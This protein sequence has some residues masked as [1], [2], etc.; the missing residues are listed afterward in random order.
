MKTL[1]H[2][3]AVLGFF[4][5]SDGAWPHDKIEQDEKTSAALVKQQ[6][7]WGIAGDPSK[8][9]RTIH[10]AMS[11]AM[12]FTPDKIDVKVGETLKFVIKNDGKLLHEFVL[13]TE[14]TLS[15]HAAMMAKH[16]QMAH[17][18]PYMVHVDPG[19]IGQIVWT[20]N[21]PGQFDFACLIAGHYQAGMVGKINVLK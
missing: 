10:V 3:F 15:E 4:G 6:M 18:E 8:A 20:F 14:K 12:R 7:A 9:G 21:R 1:L 17:D 5:M 13:G 19:R 11:D 16:P 2:V